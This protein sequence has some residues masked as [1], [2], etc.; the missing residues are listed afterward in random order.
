MTDPDLLA[1]KLAFIE[2]VVRELRELAR[3]HLIGSDIREERF[4]E[5]SLQLVIQAA[6]DAASHIVSDRRLGE[7]ETNK[8]LFDLLARDGWI[9]PAL[10]LGPIQIV[11]FSVPGRV[12]T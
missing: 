2:T 9:D 5:H 6:L 8:A 11:R 7:P 1:K 4:V 12:C 10:V 3:P